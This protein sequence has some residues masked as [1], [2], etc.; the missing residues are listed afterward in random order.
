MRLTAIFQQ[1]TAHGEAA[2][3]QRQQVYPAHQ[4][5]AA[6]DGGI[7]HLQPQEARDGVEVL[8]ADQRDLARPAAGGAVSVALDA[9]A[10]N[11]LRRF[12]Q[13]HRHAALG[14]KANPFQPPGAHRGRK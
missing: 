7:E 14:P 4:Q 6:Q 12:D 1:S 11:Q 8:G 13:A 3:L 9:A 10:G 2:P 5:V